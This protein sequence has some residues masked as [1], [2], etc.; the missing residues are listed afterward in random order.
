MRDVT[1]LRPRDLKDAV[2]YIEQPQDA[3]CSRAVPIS[4]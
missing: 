1:Y 2:Q 3:A 4:W